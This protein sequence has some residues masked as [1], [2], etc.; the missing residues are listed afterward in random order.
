MFRIP[1]K[2]TESMRTVSVSHAVP[3]VADAVPGKSRDWRV[4]VA[5][6]E[7]DQHVVDEPFDVEQVVVFSIRAAVRV[8]S[9]DALV[10]RGVF[11]AG[12]CQ[13]VELSPRIEISICSCDGIGLPPAAVD[14]D[15]VIV[16][17]YAAEVADAKG[18]FGSLAGVVETP[19]LSVEV[20]VVVIS[21]GRGP[22]HRQL[23]VTAELV[24]QEEPFAVSSHIPGIVLGT[25]QIDII[26]FLG[27]V[28]PEEG[29]L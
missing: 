5:S 27:R 3:V 23:K 18:C 25:A 29:E 10:G 26:E 6:V 17:F 1:D 7:N 12:G 4:Q 22:A 13:F 9:L 16:F 19:I 28:S 2:E 24:P 11:Q 8:S 15:D 21:P 20:E 14:L